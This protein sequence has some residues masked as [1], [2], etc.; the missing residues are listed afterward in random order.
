MLMYTQPATAH[1][2]AL[3]T[4]LV[5]AGASMSDLAGTTTKIDIVNATL[6]KALQIMAQRSMRETLVLPRYRV[7]IFAY[8]SVAVVD[9]LDGMRNLPDVIEAGRPIIIPGSEKTDMARGF[10]VVEKF[11]QANM[12]AFQNS[13]PP[14]V[15]HITDTAPSQQECSTVMPIVRRIQAMQVDDGPLLVEN[16]YLAD[17]ALRPAVQDWRQWG[18]VLKEKQLA[19][20][21]AKLLYRLSSFLPATYRQNINQYGYA[22]QAGAAHFFPGLHPDLVA[23]ACMASVVVPIK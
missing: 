13:P 17:D 3:I 9:V 7:A 4:Y 5:D 18:G 12:L 10:T 6:Y 16:I 19:S 11:L 21:G 14:L 22:L 8:N 23:L 20:N 15:C 1:A 2:P